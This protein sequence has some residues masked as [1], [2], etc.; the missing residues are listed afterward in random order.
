[1]TVIKARFDGRVFVPYEPV[2]LPVG[3][4]LEIPISNGEQSAGDGQPS[5]CDDAPMDTAK[6]LPPD[7][8]KGSGL[9][10]LA[11]VARRFPAMS[12][13]PEDYAAEVDYLYGM[14]KRKQ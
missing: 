8:E 1:M 7:V 6:S 10:G 13:V 11:E 14:P 2:D 12:E 4:E 3:F 9:R 5:A